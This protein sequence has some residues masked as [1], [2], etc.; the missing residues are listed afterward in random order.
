MNGISPSLPQLPHRPSSQVDRHPAVSNQ[1]TNA[2]SSISA[3]ASRSANATTTAEDSQLPGGQASEKRLPPGTRP[4]TP[5]ESTE[6]SVH[7]QA[8]GLSAEQVAQIRELSVRDREV[9]AH[10]AAH[11]GAAAGIAHGGMS[12][13]TVRGPDGRQYAVGGEVSIDTSPVAGDPQATLRKAQQIQRAATAPV[14][15]SNQDRQV[16]AQAAA[17]AQQARAE[18]T[19]QTSHEPTSS[20]EPTTASSSETSVGQSSEP[21][22]STPD[23]PASSHADASL[24][25]TRADAVTQRLRLAFS[26]TE[27]AGQSAK[28]TQIH[29]TA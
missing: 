20:A 18:I 6:S 13:T 5:P 8:H 22:Q 19:V 28:S 2:Q 23:K 21:D 17:M 3:T 1:Q 12:F 14:D 16:A 26:A 7:H 24:D 29:L 4:G 27:T 9:R 11:L 25:Q 15:P 10:E